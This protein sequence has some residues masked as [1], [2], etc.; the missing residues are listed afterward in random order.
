MFA[1]FWSL[2]PP[3][4]Q[5]GAS[6][7][8]NRPIHQAFWAFVNIIPS[9][10]IRKKKLWENYLFCDPMIVRTISFPPKLSIY[11]TRN[12]PQLD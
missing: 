11:H 4:F 8:L 5:C 1:Y 2:Y 12:P 7:N 6:N 3:C 10:S 9:R